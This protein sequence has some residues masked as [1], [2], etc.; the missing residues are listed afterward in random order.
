MQ[1]LELEK[2][3]SNL[4][5]ILGL[6]WDWVKFIYALFAVDIRPLRLSSVC[7][8][9]VS[10]FL[11]LVTFSTSFQAG[12][13]D[14]FSLTYYHHPRK[15]SHCFTI[16][17]FHWSISLASQKQDRSMN[18]IFQISNQ[19]VLSGNSLRV[20]EVAIWIRDSF[21]MYIYLVDAVDHKD[22]Q[23][24]P[25]RSRALPGTSDFKT[26]SRQ[27]HSTSNDIGPFLGNGE[28]AIMCSY[29]NIEIKTWGGMG[30]DFHWWRWG[31]D[32]VHV[33]WKCSSY[34]RQFP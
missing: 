18:K 26:K 8:L 29:I 7:P 20:F 4:P 11:H 6:L 16:I 22:A 13:I 1:P 9:W 19:G 31:K 23:R 28:E 14:V 24:L 30:N 25:W 3:L 10:L 2:N 15:L 5:L 34:R 33:I 17:T 32:L 27:F 21:E 12:S